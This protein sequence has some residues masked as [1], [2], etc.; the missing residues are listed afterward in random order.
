MSSGEGY[1]TM[2]QKA[3]RPASGSQE[4]TSDPNKDPFKA[5]SRRKN[6]TTLAG[7]R[8][9]ETEQNGFW[10]QGTLPHVG[11]ALGFSRPGPSQ[12]PDG[13]GQRARGWCSIEQG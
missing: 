5:S 9:N 8:L 11:W 2:A 4:G 10:P 3:T 13:A 12:C 7:K 6:M 1:H